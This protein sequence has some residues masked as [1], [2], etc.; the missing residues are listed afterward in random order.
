MSKINVVLGSD[1]E[2]M[3][4]NNEGIIVP[5]CDLLPGTKEEP[6]DLG[7]GCS[8]QV[9]NVMAELTVPPTSIPEEMYNN[10]QN[11]IEATISMLPQGYSLINKSSHIFTDEQLAHPTAKVFGCEPDYNPYGTTLRNPGRVVQNPPPK[12]NNPN[13][14]TAGGHIHICITDFKELFNYSGGFASYKPEI[15]CLPLVLDYL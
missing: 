11:G 1:P 3:V 5:S 6:Y 14:R 9:D 15:N 2:F 10:I 12:A 8:I 7:N 4:V 13:L